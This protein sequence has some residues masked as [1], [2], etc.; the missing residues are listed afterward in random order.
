[1]KILLL[2]GNGYLGSKVARALLEA[3]NSVVCTTRASS[4]L[5]RIADIKGFSA[6]ADDYIQKPFDLD[7]GIYR[8]NRGCSD[9]YS[10]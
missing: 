8:C 10:I 3:G 4:D 5:S 9:I 1:M 6:G 2:G 7:S